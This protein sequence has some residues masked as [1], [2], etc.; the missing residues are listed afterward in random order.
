MKQARRKS[1]G[2]AIPRHGNRERLG[3][4]CREM[5]PDLNWDPPRSEGRGKRGTSGLVVFFTNGHAAS[6]VPRTL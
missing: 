1:F 3:K 2:G 6:Q 4:Q 5:F